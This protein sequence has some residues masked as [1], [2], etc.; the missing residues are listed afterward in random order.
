M[1][2]VTQLNE[3]GMSIDHLVHATGSSGTQAG[4]V[5]GLKVIN[6]SINLIGFG[7]RA[8]KKDQEEAVFK[9]ASATA[10]KLSVPGIVQRDDVI[11]NCDYVGEGYGI[12][13]PSTIEAINMLAEL[14]GILLDPVYSGKGMAGLIDS[15]R[16]GHFKKG[17][18][19]VF[20]HTGGSAGLFGY[21]RFF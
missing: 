14:E 5:V 20:L 7:V 13:A 2:L 15:I 3:R 12:P 19:V 8:S 10:D 11:A 18:T 21:T 6:S 16:C 1:E 4:I 17:E 9:L